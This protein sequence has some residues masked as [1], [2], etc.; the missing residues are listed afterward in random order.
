[1]IKK[2]TVFI[3]GAGASYHYGYPTGEGLIEKVV[4]MANK[5]L[6]YCRNRLESG[7]VVQYLPDY[8]SAKCESKSGI[9][10]ANAAW[11]SVIE[12]CEELI[13]R[14]ETVRPLVIDYFLAWS[15]KL[16]PIGKF[17]VAAVILDCQAKSLRKKHSG[18][19]WYRF[20]IHKIGSNCD[21]STDIFK[22]N[23]HFVTFNY[24]ISLEYYLRRS[25]SSIELFKLS[26]IDAFL[27]DKRITHIYGSVG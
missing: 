20:I 17:M 23:V 9:K 3:L 10:G 8:V 14:I 19:D 21:D 15:E 4:E 7:Q 25:L 11:R 24:D 12:E 5:L 6:G 27:N 1:M 16:R 22:N 26:D 2:D 13:K 18:S